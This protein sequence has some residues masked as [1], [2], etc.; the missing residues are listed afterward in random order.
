MR[1]GVMAA[2]VMGPGGAVGR[3]QQ[4]GCGLMGNTQSPLLFT[5]LGVAAGAEQGG[6]GGHPIGAPA[7]FTPLSKHAFISLGAR[8]C[9]SLYPVPSGGRAV[10]P[11]H[12]A[13]RPAG[14]PTALSFWGV[15]IKTG[16]HVYGSGR[17]PEG[18]GG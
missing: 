6:Q 5:A 10:R 14:L 4:Q 11:C 18:S 3:P 12:P 2:A 9:S 15:T 8:P 16:H 13:Q 7:V 1:A 17:L